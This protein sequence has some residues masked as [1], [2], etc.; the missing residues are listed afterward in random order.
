MILRTFSDEPAEMLDLRELTTPSCAATSAGSASCSATSL[1]RQHGQQLL[2][3]VEQVR[4]L[5]KQSK[6]A[7]RIEDRNAARDQ[8]RALLAEL[9]TDQA[10]ALVRAFSA[11]FHLA[12]VAEQVHRVRSLRQRP[13]DEGWLAS[14]V[15]AVA[16]KAGAGRTDRGGRRRWPCGRCSPPTRPRPA[17]AR[18]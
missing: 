16:A 10:A 11:Y 15:A 13:A 4:A 2:D 9:P 6:E 5:T 18:S 7:A 17:A 8:V 12:N 3:L 1:V 14:S